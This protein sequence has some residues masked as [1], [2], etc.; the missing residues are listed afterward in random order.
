MFQVLFHGVLTKFQRTFRLE[1][2]F[3]SWLAFVNA[4]KFKRHR[5]ASFHFGYLKA[6]L[7]SRAIQKSK[8]VDFNKRKI[9]KHH[10]NLWREYAN[11]RAELIL[12]HELEM[13]HLFRQQYQ[14]GLMQRVF[15][16][17]HY[18][19][20][21]M[22]RERSI[23]T[24]KRQTWSKIN[25]WLDEIDKEKAEKKEFAN[26]VHNQKLQITKSINHVKFYHQKIYI[27]SH[28]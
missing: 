6:L 17:W 18:V 16:D 1:R 19:A 23:E 20:N 26:K 2:V 28:R 7:S 13:A 24:S 4:K 27:R 3:S 11:V 12:L 8:A 10:I 15:E 21:K 22:E 5:I 9:L 14:K 25:Q